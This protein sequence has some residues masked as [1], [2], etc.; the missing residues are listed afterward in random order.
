[1][2]IA[3]AIIP[4]VGSMVGQVIANVGARKQQERANKQNIEFW[5]MQN[6]YNS[7]TKQMSRLR[8]AGLNPALMYGG[9]AAGASG[10]AGN[11]A[12][13]KAPDVKNVAG[14]LPLLSTAD[15]RVK[16]AQTDNL[17]TQNTV[18][19]EEK[20]LKQAQTLTELT[21]GER[22]KFDLEFE[23]ELRETSADARKQLLDKIKNENWN[24]EQD[25][26]TK[27]RENRIGDATEQDRI[28]RIENEANLSAQQLKGESLNNALKS[29]ELQLNRMGIQKGDAI[30]FRVLGRLLEKL[31]IKF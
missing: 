7:P 23:R 3:E 12:P 17:R 20:L 22:G 1:M 10:L 13:S 19:Q 30:Y 24:L 29:L 14:N 2:S 28:Q 31:N 9:S 11:I 4:Q 26:R 25:W 21:K 16:E 6:D 15:F 5:N 8:E 18:L 27:Y